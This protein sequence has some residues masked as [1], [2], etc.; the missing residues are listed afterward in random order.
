MVGVIE[1]FRVALLNTGPMPWDMIVV[2][3]ASALVIFITGLYYFR[4]MEVHFADV[5]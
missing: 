1:G 3:A 4:R 5:A 2:G